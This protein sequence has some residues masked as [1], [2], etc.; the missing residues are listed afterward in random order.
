MTDDGSDGSDGRDSAVERPDL[1]DATVADG[2]APEDPVDGRAREAVRLAT[3]DVTAAGG[4]PKV[5]LGDLTGDGRM[6][7]LLAQGDD[8]DA[9][10]HPHQVTSLTAIDLDGT[11]HWQVGDVDPEGGS[12]GADF[13]VQIWDIDGDGYNEVIC[14]MDDEFRVIDGRTGE[15]RERHDVPAPEAHDCI[16]P[17]ALSAGS[18]DRARGDRRREQEATTRERAE[19]LV[20]DRYSQVWALDGDFEVLWTHEGNTGHYPWPHD[21]DGDGREEVMVGYDFLGPDGE[22]QWSCNDLDEHADCIWAADLDGDG[23]PEIVIGEGGV[24]AFEPD[25][26]ELWRNTEPR[27]AQH[28]APG[29]FLPDEPGLEVA[30]LDRIV[31]GGPNTTG[32]DGIFVANRDGEIVRKEDRDPG[33]WLTIVEPMTDWDDADRDYILAW[34][35]GDGTNPTLYDGHLDPVVTFPVDGY[36]VHGD[37]LGRGREQVLVAEDGTVHVFGAADVDLDVPADG[38]PLAQPKNLA[39]STLYPGGERPIGK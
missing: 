14:A 2:G 12:H 28:V 39:T 21:V 38:D 36:V 4:R 29:N 26:T 18:R 17:A 27:E 37:L 24:Y 13:P 22:V 3:V 30:G 5:L 6:E 32:R 15:I 10:H 9:T 35:R 33:G 20:K 1:D 25:G 16:V 7:L 19:L 8:I 31:R 23:E 34:R 11:V